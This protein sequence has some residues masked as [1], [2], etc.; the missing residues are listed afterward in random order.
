M[1][2]SRGGVLPSTVAMRPSS[3]IRPAGDKF[4]RVSYAPPMPSKLQLTIWPI[5]IALIALVLAGCGSSDDNKSS[6]SS[7]TTPTVKK[8]TAAAAQVPAKV[9]N[10][11]TL[12][13]AADATYPPNEFF[14]ADGK[15]IQ[16]MDADLAKAIGADLGLKVQV[17]NANFDGILP[18]LS[19]GKYDLGMSSFTDTK[20]REKTV[21]FVTY[22]S[23]RTSFFVKAQGGPKI[24]G[25]A[26]LCGHKVS[27]E[28]GTTQQDDATKQGKK[29]ASSGKKAVKVLV[30]PDQNGANL[31]LTSGRADISMA[32][33][34]VAVYVTKKSNGQ[35]KLTGKDYGPFP[36]GI[37]I[38]KNSGMAKP[39]RAALKDLISNGAYVAILK[40][41]GIQSGAITDPKINGATS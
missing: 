31:A 1:P 12:S 33:T 34:P 26:D 7:S 25:L 16:G 6:S 23:V 10:K 15:T 32:D 38:P 35:L 8:N 29:C 2:C 5:A 36:Y 22:F 11:G 39:I 21:D 14:A 24:N 9:K 27:V 37:A 17:K 18:G 3:T 19:A 28:K 13:I 41:W 30:F 20:E 40:K 4:G